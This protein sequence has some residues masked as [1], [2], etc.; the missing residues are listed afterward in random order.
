MK[1]VVTGGDGL[2]ATELKKYFIVRPESSGGVVD[3]FFLNRDMLDVTNKFDLFLT[4]DKIFP[5]IVIHCAALTN[6]TYVN[7]NRAESI[8]VNIIGTAHLAMWCARNGCRM[9]YISTDYIYDGSLKQE[10]REDEAVKPNNLY[11]TT[12]LGGECAVE[13]VPNHLIIRTSFGAS[14]FPYEEA[15]DDL[16]VSKD[17]VDVIAPMI[18]RAARSSVNG[19]LNIGTEAKSVYDY[20]VKRNPDVNRLY[21]REVRTNFALNTQRYK[22]EIK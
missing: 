13:L 22:E 20:A 8:E 1:I 4:L 11:A 3:M 12:K 7:K 21:L 16:I 17:Y 6:S 18:F 19:I 2:L 9:V 10:H 15:Y 14:K 5:D